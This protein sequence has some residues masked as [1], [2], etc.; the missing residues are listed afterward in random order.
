V[1]NKNM[2]ELIENAFGIEDAKEELDSIYEDLLKEESPEV[3]SKKNNIEIERADAYI[4]IY[5]KYKEI[6][7][8]L[9]LSDIES[10]NALADTFLFDLIRAAN[11][12][13]SKLPR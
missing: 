10:N 4:Y 6:L 7:A 1:P 8:P 3:I 5:N 11:K 12:F 13:E 9:Y 2:P